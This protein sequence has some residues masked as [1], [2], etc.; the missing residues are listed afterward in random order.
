MVAYTGEVT[1]AQWAKIEPLLPQPPCSPKGAVA[2]SPIERCSR[3]FYGSYAV[4]HAGRICRVNT[5]PSA[6]VGVG[7]N[8]GKKPKYG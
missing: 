3:G 8:N 7:C 5:L 2:A 6:P 4:G 1:E